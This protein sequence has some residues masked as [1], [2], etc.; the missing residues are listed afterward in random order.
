MILR[1]FGGKSC[2]SCFLW[3]QGTFFCLQK[4][5]VFFKAYI[6]VGSSSQFGR[7]HWFV[8]KHCGIWLDCQWPLNG[9]N[10]RP[11]TTLLWYCSGL[12][13]DKNIWV[14]SCGQKHQSGT[15]INAAC[16]PIHVAQSTF[17]WMAQPTFLLSK[18]RNERVSFRVRNHCF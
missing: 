11:V 10:T 4:S 14:F 2:F 6:K 15:I 16:P 18:Y 8:W 13:P 1:V 7:Q 12:S 3:Y 17:C 9:L 5:C